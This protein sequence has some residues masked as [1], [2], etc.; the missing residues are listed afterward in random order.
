L[1]GGA[2]IAGVDDLDAVPAAAVEVQITQLGQVAGGELQPGEADVVALGIGGP[3]HVGLLVGLRLGSRQ[4]EGV[5][6]LEGM[7]GVDAKGF[8]PTSA[9]G[10]VRQPAVGQ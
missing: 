1:G 7:L 3:G 8:M 9:G 4:V 10:A 6:R 5:E 2:N